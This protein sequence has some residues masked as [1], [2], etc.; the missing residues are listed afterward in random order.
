MVVLN[1]H[2]CCW[3]LGVLLGTLARQLLTKNY[4]AEMSVMTDGRHSCL[5]RSLQ[6]VKKGT[7][8]KD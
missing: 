5:T 2:Y 8:L 4:L 6:V 7:T 1:G 3:H